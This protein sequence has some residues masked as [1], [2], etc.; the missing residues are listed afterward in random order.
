MNYLETPFV[1][2][3]ISNKALSQAILLAGIITLAPMAAAPVFAEDIANTQLFQP[4]AQY[5][6][7][8]GYQGQVTYA[9]LPSEKIDVATQKAHHKVSTEQLLQEIEQLK[10]E[11]AHL[12]KL[13]TQHN[14]NQK[15]THNNERPQAVALTN[16]KSTPPQVS[17]TAD[18]S[19]TSVANTP[20]ALSKKIVTDTNDQSLQNPQ[21]ITQPELHH[22]V[23]IFKNKADQKAIWQQLQINSQVDRWMGYNSEKNSY[24]IYVG[25]YN[26]HQDALKRQ[27]AISQMIGIEPLVYKG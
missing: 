11:N 3:Q 8:N 1:A 22:V 13:L 7:I 9:A 2:Y 6:T 10:S 16:S 4:K 24:F 27:S 12:K 17:T 20:I 14:T 26:S 18:I 21:T 25:A 19:K 23:Y 15:K 5:Q